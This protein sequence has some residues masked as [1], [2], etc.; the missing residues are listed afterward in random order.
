M[1]LMC[2]IEK[3][4]VALPVNADDPRVH[5]AAADNANGR[6]NAGIARLGALP[7][8]SA[9]RRHETLKTALAAEH[10]AGLVAENPNRGFNAP[11]AEPARGTADGQ[12]TDRA[13]EG[14]LSQVARAADDTSNQASAVEP[15]HSTRPT[16]GRGSQDRA[17]NAVFLAHGRAA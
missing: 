15:A 11:D 17:S 8:V 13:G 14:E 10:H 4:K 16:L 7:W 3:R 9:N 1:R 2:A 6:R 5:T 12:Y